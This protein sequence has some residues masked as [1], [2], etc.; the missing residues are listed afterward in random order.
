M[1]SKQSVCV[2]GSAWKSDR[3]LVSRQVSRDDLVTIGWHVWVP[4][5][6]EG[7]AGVSC[8]IFI[9][10]HSIYYRHVIVQNRA[11]SWLVSAYITCP[12]WLVVCLYS[13][14]HDSYHSWLVWRFRERKPSWDYVRALDDVFSLVLLNY[15]SSLAIWNLH[16]TI[17]PPYCYQE[18]ITDWELFYYCLPVTCPSWPPRLWKNSTCYIVFKTLTLRRHYCIFQTCIWVILFQLATWQLLMNIRTPVNF[19]RNTA[20]ELYIT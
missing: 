10:P 12:I 2:R 15:W 17:L 5:Y 11:L 20:K 13:K 19:Q 3:I 14:P 6:T 18:A 8:D 4:P 7:L 9:C 16:R 1:P